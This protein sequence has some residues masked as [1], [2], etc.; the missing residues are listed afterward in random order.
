MGP[1]LAL[2]A[3]FVFAL[4]ALVT[5]KLKHA[6]E[7]GIR[8]ESHLQSYISEMQ[9][10]DGLEWRVIS[11]R[12]AVPTVREE[13]AASRGRAEAHLAQAG[14]SGLST[15]AAG[16]ITSLTHRYEQAVDLEMTLLG[17]GRAQEALRWDQTG[18]DPLFGQLKGLLDLQAEELSTQAS[19]AQRLGDAGLVLPVL[20]SLGLVSVV[21]SRR[22][23]L[24][25]R[26]QASR[27]SEARYRTLIDKSSDLVLVVD[28]AG[29][30]SFASPSAERMLTAGAG[31]GRPATEPPSDA[32]QTGA[33]P[34]DLFPAVDPRDRERLS[35]ALQTA[36]AGSRSIGEFRLEGAHGS[37]TFEVT[38]QDLTGDPSVGG[39]LLTAHDVTD[40]LALHQRMEHRALH[41]E[42]TGLPNRALLLDRFERALLGAERS[43]TSVGLLLLDLERFK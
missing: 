41:D 2:L 16:R 31:E 27:Q 15:G 35:A 21:Q 43:G 14:A 40:R 23:R 12:M 38:V 10:Q 9:I 25:V 5:L 30:T 8:A 28:R 29:R 34:F 39:L 6:G 11:G 37:A 1:G 26:N 24:D 32:A 18:V 19:K 13:V 7:N 33:R 42:L 22:R 36:I 4:T 17:T 3:V 20:L